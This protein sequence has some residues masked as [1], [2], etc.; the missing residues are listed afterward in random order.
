MDRRRPAAGQ[1][2]AVAWQDAAGPDLAGGVDRGD[3]QAADAPAPLRSEHGVP[4]QHLAAGGAQAAASTAHSLCGR[5][6]TTVTSIPAAFEVG[7]RRIGGRAGGDDHRALS[8]H[9]A[10]AVDEHAQALGQHDARPVV[11]GE[12]Q[13][14][15]V[16][17]GRQHHLAGAHLPQP[18][19]RQ[20]RVR[21]GQVVGDALHQADDVVGVV[22][23]GGGARQQR[24][25]AARPSSVASASSSQA[26]A[27]LPSI[28]EV[29]SC[30]SA[31]PISACSSTR[32]TRSPLSAAASA[33]ARPAGPAPTTSTSQWA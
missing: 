30:S 33:A 8:R 5:R 21:V 7:R 20:V 16:R 14:A 28:V 3:D 26:H 22:A 27:D 15:L 17:A 6:S 1:A 19:A 32:M 23:E 9:H 2:D 24:D 4:G 10:V 29:S 11:A 31:P 18:L 12:H 25:V 13:R